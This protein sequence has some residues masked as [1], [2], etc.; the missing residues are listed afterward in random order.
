V[1]F[2]LPPEY[3]VLMAALLSIALGAILA[4]AKKKSRPAN[5]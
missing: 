2:L 3:R 5:A 1:T 4:F